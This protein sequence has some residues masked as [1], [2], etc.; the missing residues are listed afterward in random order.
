MYVPTIAREIML[1]PRG[2]NLAGFA[3]GDGCMGLDV[4]CGPGSGGPYYTIEF[5]YG[6]GRLLDSLFLWEW[7]EDGV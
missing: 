7:G 1:D 6:H 2:L 3:V 4:L 5:F